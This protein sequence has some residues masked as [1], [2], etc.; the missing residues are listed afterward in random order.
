ML[1]L[2]RNN[3]LRVEFVCFKES[4]VKRFCSEVRGVVG[5]MEIQRGPSATLIQ[6]IHIPK[7]F[8]GNLVSMEGGV[9]MK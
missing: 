7:E 9:F 4:G 6:A 8:L 2:C 5:I 3:L 1:I